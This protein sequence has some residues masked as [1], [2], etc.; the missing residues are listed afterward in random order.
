[1]DPESRP[2][3]QRLAAI[4]ALI[5]AL[6]APLVELV[7]LLTNLLAMVGAVV[8]LAVGIAAGWYGIARRGVLHVAGLAVAALAAAIALLLLILAHSLAGLV[9]VVVIAG[10]A[11]LGARVAVAGD[12]RE[13]ARETRSWSKRPPPK[14]PVLLMNPHSGGGK[15]GRFDLAREA[16][17]RGIEAIEL[18]AGDDLGELARDAVA[19]G[20]DALGMAGGDGSLA[21]VAAVAAEAGLPFIAVPAGTRNHFALDAGIDR[22]DVVGA[23]DA[24]SGLERRIDLAEVNGRV[25]L[26]NVSL[27]V[28][29]VIV[30]SPEYRDAKAA[31]VRRMLPELIGPEAPPFDLRLTE[32]DGTPCDSPHVVLISNNPYAFDRL[33]GA[34]SRPRLDTGVLGV[35]AV[36]IPGSVQAA[37]FITVEAMGRVSSFSGWREWTAPKLQVASGAEVAAA[38]DGEAT[39]LTPPLDFTMRPLALRARISPHHPGV[40]PAAA[41]RWLSL[42]TVRRVLAVAR[43]A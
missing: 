40:S 36:S 3:W 27:G 24:F 38:I 43:G 11:L 33:E 5:C 8:A 37:E 12:R 16:R 20:A 23:L 39:T 19:R 28:Y 32:P 21:V 14:H 13:A 31:T 15:V 7:V 1:M 6:L 9:A 17:D 2:W 35:V 22:D 26:N 42:W 25:F 41:P 34:G 4:I 29:A 30:H 18:E 10:L